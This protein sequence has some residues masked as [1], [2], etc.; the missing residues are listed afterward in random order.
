MPLNSYVHVETLFGSS[1]LEVFGLYLFVPEP[2]FL[3]ESLLFFSFKVEILIG[4]FKIIDEIG[5]GILKSVFH[6]ASHSVKLLCLLGV[7]VLF[8]FLLL[9]PLSFLFDLL[10]EPLFLFVLK[11]FSSCIILCIERKITEVFA[12]ELATSRDTIVLLWMVIFTEK[13]LLGLLHCG[14]VDIV[15]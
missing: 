11:E 1:L 13:G 8:I 9:S 2:G 15:K 14:W 7:Q 3:L 6:H 12:F 10:V 5:F 4:W